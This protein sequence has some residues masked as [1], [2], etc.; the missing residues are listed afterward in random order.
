MDYGKVAF[1]GGGNMARALA[2]GM[3]FTFVLIQ[4]LGLLQ[5]I[6]LVILVQLALVFGNWAIAGAA[7][8]PSVGLTLTS[9]VRADDGTVFS[10]W[11]RA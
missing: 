9:M 6:G 2:G 7:P 3:L 11:R 8:D 1:V 4:W 5:T 10:R